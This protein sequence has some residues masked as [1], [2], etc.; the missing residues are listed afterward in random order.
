MHP[1]TILILLQSITVPLV[2][3][4]TKLDLLVN[5]LAT[6]ALEEGEL[7]QE[8]ASKERTSESLE[9]LCYAPMRA[10]AES[11][12]VSHVAVSSTCE[13]YSL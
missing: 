10:A 4:F 2:V 7:L 3:V 12:S 5:T 1:L 11:D 13:R 9:R 6:E 8:T